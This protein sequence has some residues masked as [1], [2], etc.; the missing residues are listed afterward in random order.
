VRRVCCKQCPRS[1]CTSEEESEHHRR[2]RRRHAM[3]DDAIDLIPKPKSPISL[4]A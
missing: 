2:R 1:V 3:V 4:T